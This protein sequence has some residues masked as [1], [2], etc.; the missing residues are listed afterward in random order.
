[1]TCTAWAPGRSSSVRRRDPRSRTRWASGG[2]D[3]RR[4]PSTGWTRQGGPGS[5]SAGP[6]RTER[7]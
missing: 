1:M 3:R 7:R 6:Q 2:H 4:P 5:V